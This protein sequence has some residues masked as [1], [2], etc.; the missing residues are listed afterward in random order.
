MDNKELEELKQILQH[1]ELASGFLGLNAEDVEQL[2]QARRRLSFS[3][4]AGLCKLW[5]T[6][7]G[8]VFYDAGEMLN[9]VFEL[10]DQSSSEGE[11][12][13]Y[14]L[15]RKREVSRVHVE[16]IDIIETV[17]KDAALIGHPAIVWAIKHW[18]RVIHA[19]RVL[20]HDDV[21]SR[22]GETAD[23]KDYY[24]QIYIKSAEQN[25]TA[26]FKALQDGIKKR[27]ISPASALAIRIRELHLDTEQ[28][29]LRVTWER[30]SPKH[31][32]PTEDVEARIKTIESYLKQNSEEIFDGN[33][34]PVSIRQV[35]NFLRDIG[36]KYV[37]DDKSDGGRVSYRPNWVIFRNAFARWYF[38]V[39]QTTLHDYLTDARKEGVA[40]VKYWQPSF[41]NPKVSFF[42]LLLYTLSQELV[43]ASP[44][45]IGPADNS[46]LYV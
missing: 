14:I 22:D 9:A 15:I 41:S 11:Q 13:P 19:K 39:E 1:A 18:E 8:L 28:N 5:L 44:S 32:D 25:L 43:S 31:I 24:E 40:E 33:H 29:F 46:D 42:N 17:R 7:A 3:E 36:Q 45:F 38:N 27:A 2:A 16:T 37:G 6:A 4:R 12:R 30:L 34:S 26:I 23:F 10:K 20:L 35:I 21:F